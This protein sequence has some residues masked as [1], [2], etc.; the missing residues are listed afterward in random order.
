MSQ[1]SKHID[2]CLKKAEKEIEEC[3]GLGKKPKHR[4]LLKIKSD[5]DGAKEHIKKAEHNLK[6]SEYLMKGDF[7][8][9]SITTVFYSM[10][11]CFLAI[12]AKFGYES[13]NQTCTIAL[14]EYLKEKNKIDIDSKF[15]DMFKYEETKEADTSEETKESVIEMG[16][17]LTYGT[18]ITFDKKKI[19][20]LMENCKEQIDLTKSI[21]HE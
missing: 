2:W 6:V 13:G 18:D 15:I 5:N 7:T 8:D 21:V 3:K 11:H 14:I 9:I 20:E 19:N 16:E 12:A 10:Y 17:D 4:G 1:A